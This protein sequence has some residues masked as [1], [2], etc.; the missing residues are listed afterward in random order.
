[1]AHELGAE[2]LLSLVLVVGPAAQANARHGG[3]TASREFVYVIE[4]D[5][6]A[7][8]T[9]VPGVTH[10]RAPAPVSFPDRA[11][12]LS[13][14]LAPIGRRTPATGSG[15]GSGG[16]LAPLEL[17]DQRVERAV[18]HPGDIGGRDLVPE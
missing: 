17:M 3:L 7:G 11:P 10:K 12:N 8:L 14:D 13:G 2:R 1:V 4:L 15:L 6:F 18:E 5:P 9:T 16:E